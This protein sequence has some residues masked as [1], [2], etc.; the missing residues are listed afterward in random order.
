M[1]VKTGV[2]LFAAISLGLLIVLPGCRAPRGRSSYGRTNYPVVSQ[3]WS[4]QG[5][6]TY[7]PP[8]AGTPDTPQ[9]NPGR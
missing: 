9:G 1:R 3:P 6:R 5:Y 7:N 2:L 8:P 4:T